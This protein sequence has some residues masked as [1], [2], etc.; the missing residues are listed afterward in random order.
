[1]VDVL[2]LNKC[3]RAPVCEG[4]MVKKCRQSFYMFVAILKDLTP[5]DLQMEKFCLMSL[6]LRSPRTSNGGQ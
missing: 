4:S 5:C 6:E 2:L 3:A 1:M